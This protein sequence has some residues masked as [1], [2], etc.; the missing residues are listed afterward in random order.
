MPATIGRDIM[1]LE[2]EVVI[3]GGDSNYLPIVRHL[4]SL[5]NCPKIMMTWHSTFGFNSFAPK[6]SELLVDWV[7][8]TKL[9]LVDRM[10]F[11]RAGMD[12]AFSGEKFVHFPNR[13]PQK[14]ERSFSKH[15]FYEDGQVHLGL[16]GT[17]YPWKNIT[18]FL[19]A[20]SLIKNCVVH[21]NETN[22][23]TGKLA[24]LTG[25]QVRVHGKLKP[26]AFR[27]ILG[28][29]DCNIQ[30]GFTESF[31]LTFCESYRLGV[32][33]LT[34]PGVKVLPN[35]RFTEVSD[36]DDIQAIAVKIGDLVRDRDHI[37][38]VNK[39]LDVLDLKNKW[40]TETVLEK[41]CASS[42]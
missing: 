18:S 38:E 2:P 17:I 42:T 22:V 14:T 23:E 30:G 25:V 24:N 13:V 41:L 33:C 16:F 27:G 19:M 31:G 10:G 35:Y 20:A 3:L 1:Q 32:P 34:T 40:I 29:M 9:G 4:R 28:S 12:Q 11:V 21:V 39:H 5:P 26:E 36:P 6:D 37:Q 15:H 8:A 7:R